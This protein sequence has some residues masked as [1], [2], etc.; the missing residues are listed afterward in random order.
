MVLLGAGSVLFCFY[1]RLPGLRSDL[2]LASLTSYFRW[3]CDQ[4]WT[5]QLFLLLA[6]VCSPNSLIILGKK[7]GKLDVRGGNLMMG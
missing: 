5:C 4:K 1:W 2:G 7:S 6:S 3:E